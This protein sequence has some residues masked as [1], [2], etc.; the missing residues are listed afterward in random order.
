MATIIDGRIVSA[1]I[2]ESLSREVQ[3]MVSNGL[4]PPHLVAVLVGNDGGS[5]T[6]VGAKEKACHEVGFLGTVI[7]YP[8]TVSEAELLEKVEEINR[9]EQIDG[10]I[11]QLP[12]PRHIDENK[13]TLAIR[14]EKDVDGFH[15]VNMGRL[16]K[17][18]DGIKPA[19]PYGITLMLKHYGI[20]T[21]GKHVVVIG[22]S[23][24]VGRPMSI[25]LSNAGETGNATVTVCHSKTQ[26]LKSF[27]LQAD[28][29]VA[30]LGKPG[31]LT[32]DMVKEGCVV[33]DVGT[34]RVEDLS[35]KAGW[36]LCGDVDFESV[37]VKASAITPVPGG[38][39]PMTIAGLLV[40]TLKAR[41]AN[42]AAR[43]A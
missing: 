4:R 5:Q 42:I 39:G 15:D 35:K 18:S 40:N 28:I 30:A 38:V 43:T 20:A 24:I 31:F 11:V 10:L 22:R 19:T 25:L 9:N 33:I 17:G 26:N 34:T 21:E 14:P 41:K 1:A 13:V 7:R 3:T 27:T 32:G 16:A 12:L 36:R 6:Y 2:R 23:N 37:S 8:D 29:V